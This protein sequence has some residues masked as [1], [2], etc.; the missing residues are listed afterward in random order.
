V[1][2]QT[3]VPAVLAVPRADGDARPPPGLLRV[4]RVAAGGDMKQMW[5]LGS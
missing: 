2:D 5:F 3:R 4:L 1:V